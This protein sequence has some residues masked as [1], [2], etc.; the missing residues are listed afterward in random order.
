MRKT[1]QYA[2]F[3]LL[4]V[5]AG[6]VI[7]KTIVNEPDSQSTVQTTAITKAAVD[8]A[9]QSD[10]L[11][12]IIIERLRIV[13]DTVTYALEPADKREVE[14]K[15]LDMY[16]KRM[17]DRMAF[18]DSEKTEMEW[19]LGIVSGV[20]TLLF[21][22]AVFLTVTYSRRAKEDLKEAREELQYLKEEVRAKRE[23][24]KQHFKEIEELIQ[25]A[26]PIIQQLNDTNQIVI[27]F[28]NELEQMKIEIGKL[29]KQAVDDAAETA[30]HRE[31]AKKHSEDAKRF[32]E[33]AEEKLPET[34]RNLLEKE[35]RDS[36]GKN[37]LTRHEQLTNYYN[38]ALLAYDEERW[39]DALRHFD[40]YLDGN[41]NNAEVWAMK[42]RTHTF[43]N[44]FDKAIDAA[45][46]SLVI[47]K[48]IS[49]A[50]RVLAYA[51]WVTG[52]SNEEDLI[53]LYSKAIEHD[54]NDYMS[55]NNRGVAQ[56]LKADNNQGDSRALLLQAIADFEKALSL[57]PDFELAKT[58]LASAQQKLNDLTKK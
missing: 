30:K 16:E 6:S 43:L 8:T 38:Q 18:V 41:T 23:E 12:Q 49:L 32:R 37:S 48:K 1:L 19:W 47:D 55:H 57:K 21:G 34:Q 27:D 25:E 2:G 45:N 40:N 10:S 9:L 17:D 3:A 15:L 13:T 31:S 54:V 7:Y 39:E 53:K 4:A 36:A 35:I 50:Y 58:N 20:L 22:V 44:Q 33:A 52:A 14:E 56:E 11:K 42:A 28:Q 29:K 46:K 24:F 5:F 26:N 51:K